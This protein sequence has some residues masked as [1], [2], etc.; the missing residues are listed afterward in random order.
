MTVPGEAA[1]RVLWGL[2]VGA[3]LGLFYDFLRPLRRRHNAPAD[4]CFVVAVLIGWIWYSFKI[5]RGDIR[6]GGTASLGIGMLLWFGTAGI[7]ARKIFHW[8]WLVIF[9]IFYIFTL[10]FL[11]IFEKILLFIKKVFA[12]GKKR[13]YNR[14]HNNKPP[15]TTGGT[16]YE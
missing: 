12:Y 16:H 6:F 14:K 2:A 13:G 8:F 15:D 11:K 7:V 4:L 10:P 9:R 1:L 5:C 3:L